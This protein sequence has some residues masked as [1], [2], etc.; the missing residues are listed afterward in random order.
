MLN[1]YRNGRNEPQ[2]P[3]RRILCGSLRPLRYFLAINRNVRTSQ[4]KYGNL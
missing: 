2:R 3:Q 4:Y 1:E